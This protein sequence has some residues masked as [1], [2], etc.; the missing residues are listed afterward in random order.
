MSIFWS[1]HNC[2]VWNGKVLTP[3]QLT[4]RYTLHLT[5]EEHSS[6]PVKGELEGVCNC[7]YVAA[8]RLTECH[9]GQGVASKSEP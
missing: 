7:Y 9:E 6:L 1:E 5:G 8:N 4:P 2:I 3:T